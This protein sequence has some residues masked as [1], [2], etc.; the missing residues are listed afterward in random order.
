M[1]AFATRLSRDLINDK[2]FYYLNQ[3]Y[4]ATTA[5]RTEGAA[6]A[7]ASLRALCRV[8]TEEHGVNVRQRRKWFSRKY[9]AWVMNIKEFYEDN[10]GALIHGHH[11]QRP[12]Q[13]FNKNFGHSGSHCENC[14]TFVTEFAKM[15][16]GSAWLMQAWLCSHFAPSLKIETI[17]FTFKTIRV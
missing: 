5:E 2:V 11:Q 9:Y 14:C 3:G 8:A 10:I 15:G 1:Q 12:Q 17:L 6:R 16:C 13:K 4:L 7:E